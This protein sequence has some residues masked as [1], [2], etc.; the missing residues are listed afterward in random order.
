MASERGQIR[1][2]EKR[3]KR[4]L[5]RQKKAM[6][7]IY[8]VKNNREGGEKIIINSSDEFW[9]GEGSRLLEREL[10]SSTKK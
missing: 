6:R 3:A 8:A 9:G 10:S 2:K 4:S 7:N 1:W 5:G